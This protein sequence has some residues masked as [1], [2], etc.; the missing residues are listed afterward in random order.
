MGPFKSRPGGTG[1]AVHP[2]AISQ[3]DLGISAHVKREDDLF[4]LIGLFGDKHADVIC[5][6]VARFCGQHVEVGARVQPQSQLAGLQIHGIAVGQGEWRA[7]ELN[8]ADTQ[9]DVDHGRIANEDRIVNGPGPQTRLA[10][11]ARGYF[12]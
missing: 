6:N 11:S 1:G 7:A 4:P 12:V 5:T 10:G 9:Q 3:D 8:W 2:I